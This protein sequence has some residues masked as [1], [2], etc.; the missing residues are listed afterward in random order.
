MA[1][2]SANEFGPSKFDTILWKVWLALV[3]PWHLDN[4]KKRGCFNSIDSFN[5]ATV[6]AK[7]GKYSERNNLFTNLCMII[8]NQ[9][10]KLKLFEIFTSLSIFVN[11]SPLTLPPLSKEYKDRLATG[12]NVS[13]LKLIIPLTDKKRY[14]TKGPPHHHNKSTILC[15]CQK[16]P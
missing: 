6:G 8:S 7:N 9:R 14:W 4:D 12:K 11:F 1:A 3:T 13:F 15:L 5:V 2:F 16:K 10:L